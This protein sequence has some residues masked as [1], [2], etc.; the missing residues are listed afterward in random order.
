M[1]ASFLWWW[2]PEKRQRHH[3][4]QAR[5]V[6]GERPGRLRAG[7]TGKPV[8]VLNCRGTLLPDANKMLSLSSLPL[9][10]AMPEP[11]A[12][13]V[14]S[15][16]SGFRQRPASISL[17]RRGAAVLGG[18]SPQNKRSGN[19]RSR[20]RDGRGGGDRAKPVRD[21]RAGRPNG[22]VPVGYDNQLSGECRIP[23]A[24]PT[25]HRTWGAVKALYR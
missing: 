13:L 20:H 10:S 24:T 12:I 21:A 25:T 7:G 5:E 3:R 11:L 22:T 16:A 15:P 18:R 14:V 9:A 2:H 4:E 23:D 17:G 19:G 6:V 8:E 1:A